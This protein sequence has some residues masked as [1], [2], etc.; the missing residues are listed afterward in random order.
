MP[1]P[2]EGTKSPEQ[3]SAEAAERVKLAGIAAQ[4]QVEEG[5]ANAAPPPVSTANLSAEQIEQM[6]EQVL[7]VKAKEA[8]AA[9]RDAEFAAAQEAEPDW[10]NLSEKDALKMGNPF[11]I[12]VYEHEVPNYMD[13]KLADPEYVVVWANRD[14]RRLGQLLAEGYEFLKKEHVAP[15]FQTPLKFDSE[16][17]YTYVDVVAMRAHKRIVFGKRRKVIDQSL[18]QLQG[19]QAFAKSKLAGVINKD[20]HLE[21]AFDSGELSYYL[22]EEQ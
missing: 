18:R 7:G 13:I 12:P 16:G 14:Q 3:L 1:E 5:A 21:E 2:K 9:K 17:M 22:T 15:S 19:Q 10:A 8:R 11:S 20:P 4:K 6:I